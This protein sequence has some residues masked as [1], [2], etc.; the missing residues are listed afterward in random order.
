M[1]EE[2]VNATVEISVSGAPLRISFD[3]PDQTVKLRRMLPVFHQIS[4]TFVRMGVENVEESGKKITCRAGCGA[5]CR[6]L[7]PLSETEAYHIAA[8]VDGM[9]EPR[10]SQIRERFE[11]GLTTLNGKRFFE[12]L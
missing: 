11:A 1:S 10:R 12:R 8:L 9:P 2:L 5:C 6:Q 3:M 7:V 4:N